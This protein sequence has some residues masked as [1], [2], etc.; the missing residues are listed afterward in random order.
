[1]RRKQDIATDIAGAVNEASIEMN[2]SIDK[3]REGI[4]DEDE[5]ETEIHA[6]EENLSDE[7]LGALEEDP[8]SVEDTEGWSGTYLN[9]KDETLTVSIVDSETISFAF[10][11]S[12][13]PVFSSSIHLMSAERLS[14]AFTSFQRA[15][16]T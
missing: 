5:E 13:F 3:S 11:N 10:T 2:C 14:A 6:E 8:D 4:E 7:Q 9:E 12:R 1:M 16:N 15:D